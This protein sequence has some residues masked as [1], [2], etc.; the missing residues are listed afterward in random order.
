MLK[1]ALPTMVPIPRSLLVTKVPIILVKNSGALVPVMTSYKTVNFL[2]S[3][4]SRRAPNKANMCKVTM[5]ILNFKIFNNFAH[6]FLF[7]H[8]FWPLCIEKVW[9]FNLITIYV[10][11]VL[12]F[13][14][15]NILIELIESESISS[16]LTSCF[17]GKLTSQ[18]EIQ[19]KN[20]YYGSISFRKVDFIR[21][22]TRGLLIF[23][24]IV[25][26]ALILN[27]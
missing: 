10:A 24:A 4:V 16:S 26:F 20:S 18:T 9:K 19:L 14:K 25:L 12:R 11:T 7:G 1:T 17:K 2:F 22:F 21:A 13:K 3:A 23:H 6:F 5:P 15:S 27:S 8:A